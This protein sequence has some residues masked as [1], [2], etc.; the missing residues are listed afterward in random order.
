LQLKDQA[1]KDSL[2]IV[3]NVYYNYGEA[4][5][6]PEAAKTLDKVINIMKNDPLL[7]IDLSSH[8]DS[9]SNQEFNLKLSEQRAKAAV[10]YILKGGISK[11]R[12]SGKGYGENKILN[13]CLDGVECSEE[14][15]AINRRTEFKI[16][17]KK[18]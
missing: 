6:L 2:T 9:R 15:H 5:I 18:K 10:D 8:T 4:K 16:L 14:E 11:D 3:E 1:K 13:K 7:I 17:S 12:I